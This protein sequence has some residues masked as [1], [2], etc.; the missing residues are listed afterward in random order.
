M[1]A[2]GIPGRAARRLPGLPG[3]V[4]AVRGQ[5]AAALPRFGW[6]ARESAPSGVRPL[7][8]APV[9]L[10]RQGD[11]RCP[12][13][14][15]GREARPRRAS[16]DLAGEATARRLGGAPP[17]P[18]SSHPNLSGL[19]AIWVVH[20]RNG[21]P[22]SD[23]PGGR[24]LPGLPGNATVCQAGL[25]GKRWARLACQGDARCPGSDRSALPLV[26]LACQGMRAVRGQIAPRCPGLAGLPRKTRRPGSDGG[27]THRWV[28]HH[29]NSP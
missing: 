11:A 15:R 8:A 19:R 14:D 17:K 27:H 16:A 20:H 22:G 23:R 13:S 6:L 21:V 4:R 2:S 5:T 12:E 26:W 3:N 10:A 29:P 25:P 24:R 7:R 1:D 18:P 28:V 9:W